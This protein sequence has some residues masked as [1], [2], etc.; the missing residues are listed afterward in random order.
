MPLRLIVLESCRHVFSG[1][2]VGA[3]LVE[4]VDVDRDGGR[5]A[6]RPRIDRRNLQFEAGVDLEVERRTV[7]D[8]DLAGH[9][10]DHCK[11]LSVLPPTIA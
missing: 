3:H 9:R 6:G 10:V 4:V 11:A 1:A 8:R 5:G 7:V 2:I